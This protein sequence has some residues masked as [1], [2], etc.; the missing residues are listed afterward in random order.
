MSQVVN[1]LNGYTQI[2]QILLKI[3]DTKY[4]LHEQPRTKEKLVHIK[5][6]SQP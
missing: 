5:S 1:L 3:M 6:K 2:S 4:K